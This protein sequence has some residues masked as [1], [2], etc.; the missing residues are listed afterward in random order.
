MLALIKAI[1]GTFLVASNPDWYLESAK[2]SR[3]VARL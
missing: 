3:M 1:V 2:P